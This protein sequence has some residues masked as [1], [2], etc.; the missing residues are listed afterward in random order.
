MFL[1][2]VCLC[3]FASVCVSPSG[4]GVPFCT[5]ASRLQIQEG[6][7]KLITLRVKRSDTESRARRDKA[8]H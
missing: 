2:R 8:V 3:N 5:L 1:R 6:D 7:K 4:Q